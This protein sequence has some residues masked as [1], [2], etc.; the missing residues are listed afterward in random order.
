MLGGL[1]SEIFCVESSDTCLNNESFLINWIA[2]I[3][4]VKRKSLSSSEFS[5]GTQKPEV[6]L[7][8]EKS[9]ESLLLRRSF[10]CL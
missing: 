8:K 10:D 6:L 4:L 7:N 3:I 9:K 1:L 5:E 2:A